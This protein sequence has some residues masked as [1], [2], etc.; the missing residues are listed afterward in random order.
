MKHR[1]DYRLNLIIILLTTIFLLGCHHE[2][3]FYAITSDR[4]VSLPFKAS[5]FFGYFKKRGIDLKIDS[6]KNTKELIKF[7]NL[8]KYTIVITDEKTGKKVESLS[9]NWK[10]ICTVALKFNK[11]VPTEKKRFIL[12]VK[13]RLL[14]RKEKLIEILKGWNY[15][16]DLLKDGAVVYYLTGKEKLE[17]IKF[18]KCQGSK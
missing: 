10:K 13:N 7:I 15:G 14:K 5:K 1:L 3:K 2:E 6:T 16:V 11:K 9:E 4:Q 18:L 17:G 8:S 12:I